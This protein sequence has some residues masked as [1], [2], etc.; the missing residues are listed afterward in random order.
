MKAALIGAGRMGRRHLSVFKKMSFEIAGVMDISPDSLQ[1]AKT[2][3]QLTDGKLF[4]NLDVLYKSGPIDCVVIATTADSHGR[5]VC[6]AA[7][8]GV[9]YILVEKPLAVSLEEC[10]QMIR[11]CAKYG[12]RLAVNH[13]M[14]FMEQYA[15]T[16]ALLNSADYGGI[17]SMNVVAGNVG[18]SMNGTHYL[19]AFRFMTDDEPM[20]VT[21]WFSPEL[22]PNPRGTQFQDRAGV[23]RVVT[24]RGKRLFMDISSGQGHGLIVTYAARNGLITVNELSGDVSEDY[25]E[26]AHRS[27]PT[28]RYGMPAIRKQG[29]IREVEII[30]STAAVLNALITGINNVSAVESRLAI[31]VLVAAYTSAENNS[32]T[33]RIDHE[34]DRKRQFPWA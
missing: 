9:K 1:A 24:K 22:V 31:A 15:K 11:V 10:D 12:S 23:I 3:H 34:L 33:V 8:R 7:E 16:K 14:R 17:Q 30:D 21:A 20:E 27:L 4:N 13:Q 28:T 19:E 6:E 25:R 29:K 32:R 5:L 26:E 18:L 2:E